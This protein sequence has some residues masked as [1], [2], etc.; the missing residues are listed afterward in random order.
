[1]G[2]RLGVGQVE[3]HNL[4]EGSDG[5]NFGKILESGTDIFKGVTNIIGGGASCTDA[6]LKRRDQLEQAIQDLLTSSER[7][8]LVSYANSNIS[9]NPR[10][11]ANFRVG[12][13]NKWGGDCFHKNVGS[14]DQRFMDELDS[15]LQQRSR[16]QQRNNQG[17]ELPTTMNTTMAGISP[18][19]K[20]IMI[21][22]GISA[23]GGAAIY[24]YQEYVN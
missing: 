22:L 9:P 3:Q 21:A 19:T 11:M 16:Q 13:V 15:L 20:Y 23:L 5:P 2:Q 7:Q 10:E 24:G 6:D 17:S 4:G 12:G 18:A 14:G 1:M 8:Q